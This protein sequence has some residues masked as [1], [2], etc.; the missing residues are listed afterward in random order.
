MSSWHFTSSSLGSCGSC[1]FMGFLRPVSASGSPSNSRA[2]SSPHSL[3]PSAATPP[4]PMVSQASHHLDA[5]RTSPA[6]PAETCRLEELHVH[7]ERP[8]VLDDRHLFARRLVPDVRPLS[9]PAEHDGVALV[10]DPADGRERLADSGHLERDG[11]DRLGAVPP[12]SHP[13][14]AMVLHLPAVR[15][16]ATNTLP[17]ALPLDRL[18]ARQHLHWRRNEHRHRSTAVDR[19]PPFPSRL[20]LL[21][22]LVGGLDIQIGLQTSD[23]HLEGLLQNLETIPDLHGRPAESGWDGN[24][25]AADVEP[26]APTGVSFSTAAVLFHSIWSGQASSSWLVHVRSSRSGRTDARLPGP[27]LHP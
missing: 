14:L 18:L 9:R 5:S 26:K 20:E 27:C 11:V 12:E 7:D 16:D 2:W 1:T 23:A 15:G 8:L 17:L 10:K 6:L 25:D 4:F 21:A 22:V 3:P 13:L 19:D 24:F